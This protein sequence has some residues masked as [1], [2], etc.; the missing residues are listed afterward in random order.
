MHERALAEHVLDRPAQGLSAVDDEEDRL[1]GIEPALDQVGKQR[2]RDR[3]VLGRALVEP[4]RDLH[5]VGGD[6][7]CQRVWRQPV[8]IPR[9]SRRARPNMRSDSVDARVT[10]V[11]SAG[12]RRQRCIGSTPFPQAFS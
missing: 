10:G 2:G 3:R 6:P 5:A 1:L 7:E 9:S 12:R 4:E 11:L 8:P